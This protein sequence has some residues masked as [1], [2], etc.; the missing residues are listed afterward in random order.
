MRKLRK[1]ISLTF[2][3][4]LF[5]LVGTAFY[6]HYIGDEIYQGNVKQLKVTYQQVNQAFNLFTQRNWGVL[7]DWDANLQYI[8]GTEDTE[9]AWR[10]FADRKNHWQ[11]SDFYMF[12]ENNDYLTAAGREGTADSISGV[13]EEMFERDES[14][15]SSYTSSSGEKK[16]VFASP[17]QQPF[18]L[19]KVTYTGVAV[20]YDA[21]V[22]ENVIVKDMFG[23]QSS[24]Y[25]VNRQG[26]T[27]LSLK[28]RSDEKENPGN[29]LEFLTDYAQFTKNNKGSLESA[30]QNSREGEAKF[31]TKIDDY[32]LVCL[33]VGINDWSLVAIVQ[34]NAIESGSAKIMRVTALLISVLFG[35][36]MILI[37]RL[38]TIHARMDLEQQKKMHAV[39]EEKKQR[40][41]HLF[42]GMTQ[43]VDCYAAV[44][45][46]EDSY[47]YHENHEKRC[48]R[49]LYPEKG[50]YHDLVEAVNSRYLVLSDTENIKMNQL[51]HA[52]YLRKVLKKGKGILKIEYSGRTENVYMIMSVVAVQWDAEGIPE[53]VMLIA[54]DIGERYELENLANTDGL[55]GLF[56]ERFFSSVLHRKEKQ[57]LP[58]T[59]YYLDLDHFKP[60]NDT[61]GHDM[62]DKLLKEVAVRLLSCIRERDYAFRI[63]GDEFAL[64][65]GA[66]LDEEQGEQ[67]RQRIERSLLQPCV[68]DGQS[69]QIGVSCGCAM[70]P[71]E[72][73]DIAKIRIL[74]DRRMYEEKEKN[75]RR[76]EQ[77]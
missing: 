7:A 45:L 73:E 24:C 13:F 62:G 30:L 4:I 70:Y 3:L 26:D 47:E 54:Q 50:A 31:R 46:T 38:I 43:I 20:S 57:K 75:H 58:F 10:D 19:G 16:I 63:G 53:K 27:V 15:V 17:L 66:Q 61:Y 21:D 12:N 60:V 34:A 11:Y 49:R 40:L 55:T 51:L 41:D 39:L 74:A 48:S 28:T 65:I 77:G 18:T 71:R 69:L 56:N 59:L 64:I 5:M 25:V 44:D 72:G 76:E 33:P 35:C 14:V 37:I 52:E 1:N 67:M 22:V 9:S 8:A 23:E 32:Y 42:Y 2:L 29:I 36:L 6:Q 68:I